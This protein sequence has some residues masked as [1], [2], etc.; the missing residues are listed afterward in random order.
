MNKQLKTLV[1][2][3]WITAAGLSL[4][5]C[6]EDF[7]AITPYLV[8]PDANGMCPRY[9]LVDQTTLS[10]QFDSLQPCSDVNG[11]W[12]LPS[13]QFPQLL[14]YARDAQAACATPQ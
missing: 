5:G 12:A 7:P 11:G 9:K 3:L 14:Q 2:I 4:V 1:L 6:K 13:N 8:Q 10:F